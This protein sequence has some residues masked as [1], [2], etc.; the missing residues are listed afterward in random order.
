MK[1]K[2]FPKILLFVLITSSQYSYAQGLRGKFNEILANYIVPSFG[3]FLL[4]GALAGI[5]R[6]WDL[7]E[8]KNNDGTR[9]KGWANVGLIVGYVFA[10]SI[11][12]TAIVGIIS[13]LNIHI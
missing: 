8:D 4:I 11:V 2:F 12:I 6:N 10:A 9:Q 7:I 3:I 13:S 5:I 1:N